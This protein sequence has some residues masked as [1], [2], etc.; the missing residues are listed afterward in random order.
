MELA[1]LSPASQPLP[2]EKM[3]NIYHELGKRQ[4]DIH[5]LSLALAQTTAE[6]KALAEEHG[7]LKGTIK[8]QAE[9]I[10]RLQLEKERVMESTI[11]DADDKCESLPALPEPS[12]PLLLCSFS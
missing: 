9:E 10:R 4:S 8:A 2:S 1:S 5:A 3:R 12:S 11:Q 7:S 6:K